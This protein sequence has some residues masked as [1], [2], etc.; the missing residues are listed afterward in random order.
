MALDSSGAGNHGTITGATRSA[1]KQGRGLLFAAG[2]DVVTLPQSGAAKASAFVTVAAWVYPKSYTATYGAIYSETISTAASYR[3]GVGLTSAGKPFV[4]GRAPDTQ[5]FAEWRG[6]TALALNTWHHLAATIDVATDTVKL[7]VNAR[8]QT[9]EA[10]GAFTGGVFDPTDTSGVGVGGLVGATTHGF[11]GAVSSVLVFRRALTPAE[12]LSLYRDE[13]QIFLPRRG[14]IGWESGASV[15]PIAASGGAV[16]GGSATQSV[17][18]GLAA[19][20]HATAGGSATQSV[21][22]GLAAD[23]HA[24]AGGQATLATGG[25][26]VGPVRLVGTVR[27]AT[28]LAGAARRATTLVGSAAHV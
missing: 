8:L 20:G 10:S 9:T 22:Y 26:A 25:E 28:S 15:T 11:G 7:Y 5:S 12:I 14:V 24:T 6:N 27:R 16:A 13:N 2:T 1:G 19:D 18:Y 3:L 21:G 17:G 23:G 4:A